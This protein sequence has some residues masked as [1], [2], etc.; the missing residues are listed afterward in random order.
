MLRSR[1]PSG[2]PDPGL[3]DT[4]A[5]TVARGGM[6]T[7]LGTAVGGLAFLTYQAG[8]LAAEAAA[9]GAFVAPT[10]EGLELA[11]PLLAV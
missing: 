1:L 4:I 11:V 6:P 10:L 5:G 9:V 2:V 7:I 3:L 8:Q